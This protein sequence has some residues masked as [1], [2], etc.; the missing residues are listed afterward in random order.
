MPGRVHAAPAEPPDAKRFVYHPGVPA[1]IEIDQTP[2]AF[3]E[4]KDP[5]MEAPIAEALK[6]L[7]KK[8]PQGDATARGD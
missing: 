6:L 5:Q 4:G 2:T 7:E 3:R 1:D 8:P